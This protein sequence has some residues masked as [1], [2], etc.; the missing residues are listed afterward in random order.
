MDRCPLYVVDWAYNEPGEERL[1]QSPRP[2]LEP[3]HLVWTLDLYLED[4][5]D[6]ITVKESGDWANTSA[7]EVVCE[8]GHTLARSTEEE[9]AE[10]FLASRNL[11]HPC[12]ADQSAKRVSD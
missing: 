2:C 3:L 4:M 9:N 10:P 11:I 7:W 12:T 6:E 8:G 1:P 5:V